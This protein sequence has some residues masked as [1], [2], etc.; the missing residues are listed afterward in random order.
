MYGYIYKTTNIL[1]NKIYIGKRKGKFNKNYLGSGKYLLNAVNKYGKSNFKV[2]VIEWCKDLDDQN[3]KEIYWIS[4]YRNLDTPMYNISNGGDGGNIYEYLSDEQ[5][6]HVKRKISEYN[7]LGICGNKGKHLSSEHRRKISES[8]RGKKLT[9]EQIQHLREVHKGQKAWNK[10]LTKDD[11]RV[12]KYYRIG[13]TLSE[14]TRR[15]I[16]IG[17]KNAGID[18]SKSDETK[19]K[20]SIALSGKP[21][22]NEH[23]KKLHD[24]AV[25]RIWICNANESK[26]IYPNELDTYLQLGYLKGRKFY[27]GK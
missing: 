12:A 25:G 26:M 23:K 7:K 21:K 10:G 8:N 9:I 14:E 20:L 13:Y 27:G 17:V 19:K 6:K 15:K 1:N 24:K 4:K 16:S 18:W 5:A 11:P 3:Q 2:E 22:S